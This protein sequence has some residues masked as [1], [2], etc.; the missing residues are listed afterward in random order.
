MAGG[1]E[2]FLSAVGVPEDDPAVAVAGGEEFAVILPETQLP[3]AL[4]LADRIR[5]A[6]ESKKLIK[7]ST[8]DILGVITVSAGIARWAPGE[9]IADFI[10]RADTCLYAA[11]RTGRNKVVTETD[12]AYL[13]AEKNV[14][15]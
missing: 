7:K 15:A 8:G 12:P 10:A 1:G 14:A 13:Q 3:D 6:I 2:E 11:K 9:S 5:T 4:R